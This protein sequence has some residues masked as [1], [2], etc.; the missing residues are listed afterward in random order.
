M[1]WCF[2]TVTSVP[3]GSVPAGACRGGITA[4]VATAVVFDSLEND[5]FCDV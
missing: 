2:P 1:T 5:E 4:G 3:G